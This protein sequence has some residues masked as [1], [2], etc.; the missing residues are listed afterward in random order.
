ME[1]TDVVVAA[2][3]EIAEVAVAAGARGAVAGTAGA[4]WAFLVLVTAKLDHEGPWH[5]RM[6]NLEPYIS[7]CIIFTL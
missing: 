1:E 6:Q 5:K 4:G 7:L 2:G 3:A